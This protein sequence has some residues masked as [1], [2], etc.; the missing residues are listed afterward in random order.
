MNVFVF[1]FEAEALQVFHQTHLCLH[2]LL[3]LNKS[4]FVTLHFFLSFVN[5]H[6]YW[7]YSKLYKMN[8]C[9]FTL[10]H[11]HVLIVAVLR[12]SAPGAGEKTPRGN[13]DTVT[14]LIEGTDPRTKR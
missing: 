11:I 4:W 12:F 10:I 14:A 9:N 2:K 13:C 7:K 3:N 1:N 6:E 5:C 8:H